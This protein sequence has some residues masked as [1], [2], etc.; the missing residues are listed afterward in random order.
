MRDQ[1]PEAGLRIGL[2]AHRLAGRYPTGIGRYFQ[3]LVR[4]LARS[5]HRH[6]L[7][8]ASTRE[9]GD[10]SWV[11][12]DVRTHVVRWPRR[13][14]QLAWC[15]GTGPRLERDLGPLDVVHL[16]QPFPPVRTSA[17]QVATV[18]DLFPLEHPGWYSRSDRWTYTRSIDL[19]VRRAVRIVVPAAY[20]AD[21]V[22]NALE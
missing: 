2:F 4:A 8:A 14:V 19:L 3:E 5:A 15:L 6:E 10:I 16:L 7:V 17:P 12:D 18:H 20:V 9:A 22:I 13:P 11:P 1:G 21:R